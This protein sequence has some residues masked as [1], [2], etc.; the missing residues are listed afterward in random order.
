MLNQIKQ[1]LHQ[2]PD[3]EIEDFYLEM[4]GKCECNVEDKITHIIAYFH[5]YAKYHHQNENCRIKGYI[6]SNWYSYMCNKYLKGDK[7]YEYK[8]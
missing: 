4:Y 8:V 5:F 7:Y 6:I 2:L 3:C 1:N